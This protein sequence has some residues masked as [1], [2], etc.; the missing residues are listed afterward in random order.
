MLMPFDFLR[1]DS[2][3][4]DSSDNSI[5]DD[6]VELDAEVENRDE[7]VVIRAE[8]LQELDDIEEVQEHLR[9]D[10]IVWVNIGPL[11]NRDMADLKRAIKRLKKTIRAIDGDMAGVDESYI[12]TCPEYAEIARSTKE[13]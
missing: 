6:F 3:N 8:T 1:G 11:K 5:G 12:L 2:E 9:N 4:D 13:Q 10:H 7:K